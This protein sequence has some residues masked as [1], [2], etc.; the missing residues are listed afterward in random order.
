MDGFIYVFFFGILMVLLYV[1]GF[2]VCIFFED[3]VFMLEGVMWCIIEIVDLFFGVGFD[4]VGVG[5]F[6]VGIGIFVFVVGVY[7]KVVFIG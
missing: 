3:L 1:V 7:L 2:V 5:F 4:L 6:D